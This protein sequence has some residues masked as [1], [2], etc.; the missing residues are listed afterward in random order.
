MDKKKIKKV[1]GR[2]FQIQTLIFIVLI[3]LALS[4]YTRKFYQNK[5]LV[6]GV[7]DTKLLL[8]LVVMFCWVMVFSVYLMIEI[9][10]KDKIIINQNKVIIEKNDVIENLLY[11]V[12]KQGNTIEEKTDSLQEA[13][14]YDIE[15]SEE[16]HSEIIHSN[17][18]TQELIL[19][20]DRSDIIA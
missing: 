16:R 5:S 1:L 17:R 2:M 15:R 8:C 13:M 7:A 11:Q 4:Y 9:Y 14:D 20:N 12:I 3:S 6:F 19:D 18:N 10:K